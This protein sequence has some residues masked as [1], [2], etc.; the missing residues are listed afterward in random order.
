MAEGPEHAA[1]CQLLT[2]PK[3]AAAL[4]QI[5][6][7]EGAAADAPSPEEVEQLRADR[8]ALLEDAVAANLGHAESS[9]LTYV[10][11]EA[12]ESR[13]VKSI[14][15]ENPRDAQKREGI[16]VL[17][18]DVVWVFRRNNTEPLLAVIFEPQTKPDWERWPAWVS[19]KAQMVTQL[20]RQGH[21]DCPVKL[22]AVTLAPA[23][24]SWAAKG[25][26]DDQLMFKP[27]VVHPENIPVV[28]TERAAKD[29][30]A[31]AVLS[32]AARPASAA[33]AQAMSVAL[34]S[35]PTK[36]RLHFK[37]LILVLVPE[38]IRRMNSAFQGIESEVARAARLEGRKEGIQEGRKEGIQEGRREGE[39]ET[40]VRVAIAQLQAVFRREL[41][42][43]ERQVIQAAGAEQIRGLLAT[44]LPAL[45]D[46][47]KNEES[48]QILLRKM[49][50]RDL[51]GPRQSL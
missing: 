44:I 23:T 27:Y 9:V 17:E 2:E 14:P 18:A 31:L 39:E 22:I 36:E 11:E 25:W 49:S 35:L 7:R 15:G 38:E 33:V 6:L 26:K 8:L 32:A 13:V 40:L 16:R 20:G 10:G 41:S 51:D 47:Q 12:R 1:L 43:K 46:E 30:P 4:T 48:L 29:N 34:E 19:Y 5:V 3:L 42:D 37:N 45:K 50:S 21:P 24:A 28:D